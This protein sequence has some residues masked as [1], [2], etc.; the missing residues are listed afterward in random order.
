MWQKIEG[1]GQICH[2]W[3]Y[4]D[5][6]RI[7]AMTEMLVTATAVVALLVGMAALVL[8]VRNDSFAGPGTAYRPSDELGP[9]ASRRREA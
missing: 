1:R 3:Q 8:Y 2:W 4:S 7:T 9:L 5:E 6:R